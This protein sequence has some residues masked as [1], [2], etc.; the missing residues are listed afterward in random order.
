VYCW[1]AEDGDLAADRRLGSAD[2]ASALGRTGLSL[3]PGDAVVLRGGW[4]TNRPF[5]ERVPGLDLSAV[6]W[7]HEHSVSVYVGDIGDPRPPS[8]LLPPH[9]V[10]LARLGMPLV[11]AASLDDLA[12]ACRTERRSSFML[13]LAPSRITGTTGLV[14]NP[15]ALF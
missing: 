4:D 1:T 15:I 3:H 11:D 14:V 5:G 8:F 12:E 9:Q 7:L 10:A 13:A 6:Q 2:M